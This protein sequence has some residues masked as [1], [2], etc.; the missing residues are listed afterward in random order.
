MLISAYV[1]L[2]DISVPGACL[3]ERDLSLLIAA[4]RGSRKGAI[5]KLQLFAQLFRTNLFA[6]LRA[7]SLLQLPPFVVGAGRIARSQAES[8]RRWDFNK[9]DNRDGWDV[10]TDAGGVVKGGALWL[11]LAPFRGHQPG[12][13]RALGVRRRMPQ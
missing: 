10:R 4:A 11:T 12:I 7:H 6:L 8:V 2:H 9:V 5:P 1:T 3:N 13:T